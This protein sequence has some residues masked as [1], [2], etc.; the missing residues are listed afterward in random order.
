MMKSLLYSIEELRAQLALLAGDKGL[1]DEEVLR[2]SQKLDVLIVNYL[3][4]ERGSA[5]RFYAEAI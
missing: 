1:Q 4:R 2:L 3:A 5:K